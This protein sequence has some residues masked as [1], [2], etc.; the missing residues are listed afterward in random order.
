MNNYLFYI[1]RDVSAISELKE[2]AVILNLHLFSADKAG[3]SFFSETVFIGDERAGYEI[4]QGYH[5]IPGDRYSDDG[6]FRGVSAMQTENAGTSE[7]AA[8][9]ELIGRGA[10]GCLD[11]VR[12]TR[13]DWVI[14]SRALIRELVRP[15]AILCFTQEDLRAS[16]W[17]L[18]AV[19]SLKTGYFFYPQLQKVITGKDRIN[20]IYSRIY[21]SDGEMYRIDLAVLDGDG[22]PDNSKN[23]E[24]AFA[25]YR[26]LSL[27]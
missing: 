6:S 5:I 18:L 23:A 3:S 7:A 20:Y 12:E 17:D 1:V 10:F 16:G 15:S 27:I 9:R 22:N 21:P 19:F 2:L 25:K 4:P 26:L 8:V 11:P 14:R 24:E 13:A